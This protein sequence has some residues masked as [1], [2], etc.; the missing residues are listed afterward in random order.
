MM[1]AGKKIVT[2]LDVGTSQVTAVVAEDGA[3]DA[4][5]PRILGI[6]QAK[7]RGVRKGEI[8]DADLTTE[9][10]RSAL[11]QA[12]QS[13]DQEIRSVY[14]SVSG[15]HVR[16]FMNRGA[17]PIVSAERDITKED[18]MDVVKNAKAVNLPNDHH[19]IHT[20]QQHFS[21]DDHSGI[22]N[23]VGLLGAKIEV[24]LLAIHGKTNRL[25]NSIQVVK[26]LRIDVEEIVFSGLAGALA[27]LNSQQK[28][29]GTL[30]LDFGGGTIEYVVCYNGLIRH[31]GVLPVGGDHISNDL[32]CGF[33]VPLGRAERLK[34]QHGSA[35]NGRHLPN[36]RITIPD[37]VNQ[38]EKTIR[39]EHLRHIMSLRISECFELIEKEL[40]EAGCLNMVQSGVV[41]LGGGA[42]IPDI[43]SRAEH[44]FGVPA[45]V[46]VA[47]N[48]NGPAE[49]L[50]QPEFAVGIGLAKFGIFELRKRQGRKR[51]AT[52][53]GRAFRQWLQQLAI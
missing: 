46:G 3:S 41:I 25:K 14:L 38:P 12:E 20:V 4:D 9:D 34:I 2:G 47:G 18:I 40:E 17:H 44:A 10:V 32:A 53:L 21:V 24:D 50:E 42:R 28:E 48:V 13:A 43:I 15:G 16:S 7:S 36:Q 6:G 33:K 19:I 22:L 5:M 8:V 45:L 35:L 29:L 30:A 37:L 39:T 26:N 51:K 23:P 27:V 1:F 52:K 11:T 31:T 49:V